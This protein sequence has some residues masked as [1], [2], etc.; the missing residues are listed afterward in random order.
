M[1]WLC[2]ALALSGCGGPIPTP[3]AG[4][5]VLSPTSVLPATPPA[6]S[7]QDLLPTPEPL[8]PEPTIT[9]TSTPAPSAPTDSPTVPRPPTRTPT[10]LMR[11]SA[12]GRF[13][14]GAGEFNAPTGIAV[15]SDGVFVADR[16]NHRVQRFT[17]QG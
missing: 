10:P 5:P 4:S 14:G 9:V 16:D 1:L 17:P 8:T 11:T 2:V 6:D 12:F 7:V 3:R 13:G 15:T